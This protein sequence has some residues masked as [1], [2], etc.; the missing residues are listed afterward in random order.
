MQPLHHPGGR[1]GGVLAPSAACRSTTRLCSTS[2]VEVAM[3][4]GT[5]GSWTLTVQSRNFN[6]AVRAWRF[7]L[8]FAGSPAPGLRE[9]SI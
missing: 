7:E 9:R 4:V 6:P 1:R 8:E 2:N 3:T 5:S